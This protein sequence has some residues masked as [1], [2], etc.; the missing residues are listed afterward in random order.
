MISAWL[1]EIER[2]RLAVSAV[3]L[4]KNPRGRGDA[5]LDRE[6]EEAQPEGSRRSCLPTPSWLDEN[7]ASLMEGRVQSAI[8]PLIADANL[9]GPCL[10]ARRQISDGRNHDAARDQRLADSAPLALYPRINRR[11]QISIKPA[12]FGTECRGQTAPTNFRYSRS[13]TRH[14]SGFFPPYRSRHASR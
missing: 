9:I 1:K 4:A 3:S 10:F 8:A 14:A 11:S 2:R 7:L 6:L 5:D 13:Q 12:A